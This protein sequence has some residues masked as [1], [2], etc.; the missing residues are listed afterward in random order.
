MRTIAIAMLLL[1]GCSSTLQD[2]EGVRAVEPNIVQVYY[3]PDRFP[4]VLVA[5]PDGP[6]GYG[7]MIT[8]REYQDPIIFDACPIRGERGDVIGSAQLQDSLD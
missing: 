6:E 8:T 1:A 2:L 7:Y 4:N 3:S 5:C